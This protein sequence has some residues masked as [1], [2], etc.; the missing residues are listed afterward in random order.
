M[1]KTTK[2]LFKVLDVI[3]IF[4]LT[5]G[6]PMS[7]LADPSP[8]GATIASDLADY[9][10]GATVTLTGAGWAVD[11]AVG[12]SPFWKPPPIKPSI[13]GPRNCPIW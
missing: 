8:T 10:P 6:A 5:F 7:A 1:S 12:C 13:A 9:P 4:M 11:E 3:M 2:V